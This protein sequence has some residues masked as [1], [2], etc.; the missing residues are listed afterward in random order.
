MIPTMLRNLFNRSETR[1]VVLTVVLALIAFF[2]LSATGWLALL[3]GAPAPLNDGSAALAGRDVVVVYG[4]EGAGEDDIVSYGYVG[5]P[6][7]EK[8]AAGEVVERR[9]ENSWSRVVGREGSDIS[10]ATAFYARQ[11]FVKRDDGWHYVEYGT[12]TKRALDRYE[13]AQHPLSILLPSV[14]HAVTFNPVASSDGSYQ[15]SRD[16]T[17]TLTILF[18]TIQGTSTA[19]FGGSFPGLNIGQQATNIGVTNLAPKTTTTGSIY[20]GTFPFDTSLI[21]ANAT[22]TAASLNV[23]GTTTGGTPVTNDG[24]DYLTTV[25]SSATNYA[26]PAVADYSKIGAP[27]TNPT[28]GNATGN[29]IDISSQWLTNDGSG[30]SGL[31]TFTLN[32]TGMGWIKKAGQAST[33]SASTGITCLGV[34][35]GHDTTRTP[36]AASTTYAYVSFATTAYPGTNADPFLSVTYRLPFAFWQ[37]QDY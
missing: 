26:A 33:C 29:R 2:A 6:M 15:A 24:L 10:V 5:K 11:V 14:A 34:R 9:T 16:S 8:V 36:L 27:V 21:P 23:F 20:R 17:S 19:Y 35:E 37:F 4:N 25:Q 12:A 1:D 13:A 22:I 31:N 30:N 3:P 32:A 28:E 18:N 7:P